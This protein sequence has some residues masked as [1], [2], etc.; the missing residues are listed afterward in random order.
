MSKS[1]TTG[2]QPDPK[3][4]IIGR[5]TKKLADEHIAKLLGDMPPRMC[6]TLIEPTSTGQ[7]THYW[8]CPQGSLD[9]WNSFIHVMVLEQTPPSFWTP[10]TS[11]GM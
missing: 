8:F 4:T 2:T 5:N 7:V 6:S 3:L 1:L 10:P 11:D 9:T